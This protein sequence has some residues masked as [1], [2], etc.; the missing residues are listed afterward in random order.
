M[1]E[2]TGV[3][4]KDIPAKEFIKAF[5]SH[6]KASGKINVPEWA[7]LVKT[8]S[9]K[10]LAP[11]EADWYFVR[12]AS[13]AR[14][15]Y[16]RPGTGVGAFTTVYGGN[17][18]RKGSVPPHFS[19]AAKGIIRHILQSLANADIVAV[20]DNSKG[21]F[22]TKAGQRELDTVAGQIVVKKS[23]EY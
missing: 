12:A 17:N 16:L 5:A 20:R 11:Y 9:N 3:T 21:R 1:A 10:E 23:T 15:V 4:V 19:K 2:R 8:G 6:L 7:T 14:K 13:V 18:Y 22:M